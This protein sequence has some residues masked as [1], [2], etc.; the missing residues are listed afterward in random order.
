MHSQWHDCRSCK[1]LRPDRSASSAIASSLLFPT[2]SA[3]HAIGLIK[4][5]NTA[6][7]SLYITSPV[8]FEMQAWPPATRVSNGQTMTDSVMTIHAITRRLARL[9]SWHALAH[10][11]PLSGAREYV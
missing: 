3:K 5:N 8:Q 7:W 6:K 4:A 10:P 11:H 9:G 2:L 1:R